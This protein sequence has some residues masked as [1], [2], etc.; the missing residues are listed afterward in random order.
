LVKWVVR[1]IGIIILILIIGGV[2]SFIMSQPS[3]APDASKAQWAIQ[4]Y[5]NDALR[6]PSRVY[7]AESVQYDDDNTPVITNYWSFNGQDYKY[8]RGDKEFPLALYGK[9]DIIKRGID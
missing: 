6:I 1:G 2:V 8:T 5:S 9:I 3:Q 4:T 7:F